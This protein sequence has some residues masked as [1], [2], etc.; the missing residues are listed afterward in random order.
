MIR[1]VGAFPAVKNFEYGSIFGR[2]IAEIA[3]VCLENVRLCACF[4]IGSFSSVGVVK[5][6]CLRCGFFFRE[7]RHE[8]FIFFYFLGF[9]IF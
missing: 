4:H 8:W 3:I 5:G 9:F 6:C 2:L 1:F 7:A